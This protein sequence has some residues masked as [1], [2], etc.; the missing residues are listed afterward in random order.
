LMSSLVQKYVSEEILNGVNG[1]EKLSSSSKD[2]QTLLT[3][4]S[5]AI[6]V[7]RSRKKN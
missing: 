7:H 4:I 6:H 5:A 1:V 3:V 2:Q